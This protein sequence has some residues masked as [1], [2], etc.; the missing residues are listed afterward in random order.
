LVDEGFADRRGTQI[1]LRGNLLASL[2]ERELNHVT[3]S[4]AAES[5]LVY[6][7]TSNGQ[8]ISGIYRRSLMLNSGRFAMIDDG[9]GF[10][11]VPWRPVIEK[12][13]GREVWGMVNGHTVSWSFGKSR[14][15]GL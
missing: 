3:K 8:R 6:R 12:H 4:I 13:L 11:L 9:S 5:G 14:T 1:I 15:P 7:H 10:S 2:R